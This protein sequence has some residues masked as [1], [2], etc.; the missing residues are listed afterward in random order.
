MRFARVTPYGSA[1]AGSDDP[2]VYCEL[3]LVLGNLGRMLGDFEYSSSLRAPSAGRASVLSSCG[4][5]SPVRGE[6]ALVA[7]ALV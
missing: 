5:A 6:V 3:A 4:V 7:N 2:S 1:R